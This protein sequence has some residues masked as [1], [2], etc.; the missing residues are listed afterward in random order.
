M[1][2]PKETPEERAM[3]K[4]LKIAE[5]ANQ[6]MTEEAAKAAADV[7]YKA[8]L[9]KRLMDAQAMAC[10]C[11]VAVHVELTTKGPS[12]RFEYEDHS[13]KIYVDEILTY[14][15][16]EW[17]VECVEGKLRDLKVAQDAAT[18]R[19]LLAQSIF[20]KLTDEEKIVLK[21]NIMWL[22]LK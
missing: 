10:S 11:G 6:R 12:V 15:S 17:E 8:G 21:E 14:H 1:A 19:Q 5:E 16:E 22:K 7:V 13:H 9:P 18:A 20:N 4:A 3:R 2:K